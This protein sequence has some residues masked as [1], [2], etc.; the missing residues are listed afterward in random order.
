MGR[1]GTRAPH[2]SLQRGGETI[3]THD[4]IGPSF[5]LLAGPARAGLDEQAARISSLGAAVE[6]FRVGDRNGLFDPDDRFCTAF[7]ITPSGAVLVRPDGFISWR[8][9]SADSQSE[10]AIDE[11]MA[12]VLGLEASPA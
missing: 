12:S 9:K 5:A 4:L 6:A 8:A 11:A 2:V 7:G 10:H 1:P 3:S